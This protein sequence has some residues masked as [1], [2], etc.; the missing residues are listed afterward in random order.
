MIESML[1]GT[2]VI[3][4]DRG[5]APE[6]VNPGVTGM[7]V[8]DADEMAQAIPQARRIDRRRCRQRAVSRFSAGHMASRYVELY[9][10]LASDDG[11]G[12]LDLRCANDT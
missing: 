7:L 10:K 11:G 3:A 8:A 9:R 4:F 6:V 2:P 12:G 1:I 5:S